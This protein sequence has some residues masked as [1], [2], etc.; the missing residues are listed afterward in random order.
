MNGVRS[1]LDEREIGM[2]SICCVG[3]GAS[4]F[5]CLDHEKTPLP[6]DKRNAVLT[7][8]GVIAR[9]GTT[10]KPS[11]RPGLRPRMAQRRSHPLSTVKCNVGDHHMATNLI[12]MM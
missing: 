10:C 9:L 12:E 8:Y 3:R 2:V 11:A 4:Q 5:S 1:R 7:R 6:L